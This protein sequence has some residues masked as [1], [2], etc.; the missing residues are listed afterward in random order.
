MQHTR[1]SSSFKVSLPPYVLLLY[2][3]G[4]LI[5][6]TKWV[7]NG[8]KFTCHVERWLLSSASSAHLDAWLVV[9]QSRVLISSPSSSFILTRLDA[10]SDKE[11]KSAPLLI[12]SN[13]SSTP[14]TWNFGLLIIGVVLE[15]LKIF[16]IFI[17][18]FIKTS[19]DD[20][21]TVCWTACYLLLNTDMALI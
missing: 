7:K 2:Y 9:W 10:T 13:S 5:Q 19:I 3:N 12:N 18:L 11:T 16:I 20:P 14:S 8:N 15:Y 17:R 4:R 21:V 6:L 1:I